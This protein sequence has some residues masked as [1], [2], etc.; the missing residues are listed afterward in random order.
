LVYCWIVEEPATGKLKERSKVVGS[1][2]MTDE[3]GWERV[4][5]LKAEAVIR[6]DYSVPPGEV[7]FGELA[8]FYFERKRFNKVSTKELHEQIVNGILV[9]RWGK[10]IAV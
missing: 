7:T 5:V 3:R 8:S 10:R 1:A 6:T 2:T 9:P 4:G